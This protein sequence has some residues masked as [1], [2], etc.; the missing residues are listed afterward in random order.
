MKPGSRSKKFWDKLATRFDRIESKDEPVNKEIIARTK[1]RLT[2]NDTVLDYGCGTGT[3][4]IALTRGV[5]S[6]CGIDISRKMVELAQ[7]KCAESGVANA[8]FV[9]AT[10]FDDVLKPES[11]DAMLCLYLLHLVEDT[12]HVMRR[13]HT[14]LKPGGLMISA[15]PCVRGTAFGVVLS[16]LSR[17]GVIPPLTSFSVSALESA[18]TEGGFEIIE[19]TCL[20]KSGQQY[21]MV[22]RR[23]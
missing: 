2:L 1:S 8:E 17:F 14:L 22:D 21:Y 18:I 20:H 9:H 16:S 10:I 12:P 6:I 7:K 15:T 3:A 4:A 23:N 11:F 19:S 13:I 5:K